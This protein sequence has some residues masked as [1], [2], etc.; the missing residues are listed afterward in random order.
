MFSLDNVKKLKTDIKNIA[1][2]EVKKSNY[3]KLS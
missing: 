1:K 3:T 2:F